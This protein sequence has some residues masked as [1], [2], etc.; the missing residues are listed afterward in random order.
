MLSHEL[1]IE[2][3]AMAEIAVFFSGF[4]GEAA[5]A[6]I[7]FLLLLC[8]LGLPLPEEIP[9][10]VVGYLAYR[11]SVD[12]MVGIYL[13][14]LG[15][16]LGDFILFSIGRYA[17][18]K[19][20]DYRWFRRVLNRKRLRQ[21]RKYFNKYGYRIVFFARF[22]A[23]L[24][25]P[26]FLSAGTLRMKPQ[27]FLVLDGIAALVSVPLLVFLAYY[28]GAEIERLMML[29]K[30]TKVS[31][32]A[33]VLAAIATYILFRWKKKRKLTHNCE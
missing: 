7:F 10:F 26:I 12:L 17:G 16:M 32:S 21:C 4:S 22:V 6:A 28:F 20:F 29:I 1:L 14:F 8:G 5:L 24:R 33:V 27:V 31:L 30:T 2:W 3:R 15:I 19:I 11:G 9:L 23:G 25:A 18:I 13:T